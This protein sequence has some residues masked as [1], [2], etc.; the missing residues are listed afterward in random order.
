MRTL[1]TVTS[2]S[3]MSKIK[4]NFFVFDVET[5]KLEPMPENFVFAVIYGYNSQKVIYS[6]SEFKKEIE[7]PKYKNK[8]L[9]AHN[10]EFDLLS[11]FGNIYTEVDNTAVFNGK[12]ISAKY[13]DITFADSL[14][15]YPTSVEK[16]GKLIGLEKMKNTKVSGQK[17]RK[18]N[19]TDTDIEY[20]ITDCKIVF[21]ALLR[22]FEMTGAIKITLPSLAM[23]DF[24]KNYLPS[25][26]HFSEL[27]DE[28]YES[29]YGGRTEA[30]KIGQVNAHV[31]DINS[32][33]P[34]AMI[35]TKFPDIKNLKKETLIDVKY[36][37][38]ILKYY[39]GLASVKV[40]HKDTYFGF[41]PCRMEVNKSEKLVFPV[42]T[43]ETVVNFNELRFAVEYGA[44][45][46]LKV[47]Y[48]IF[49]NPVRS[50]F[51]N[52]IDDNYKKRNE[53]ADELN[54][55]IYKLKMNSLYGRFAMRMKLSTTYYD[56]IPFY[57]I[58]ELKE[59]DKRCDIQLFNAQ[60]NDC[61]LITENEKFK[62]SFFSIPT[63]SSY[64]TSTARIILLKALLQNENN[65][66]CY[67]DTDSIFLEGLF[68]GNISDA[69][70]DFKKENKTVIRV[71]G[72]KNYAYID[73]S[74]TEIQVIKGISKNSVKKIDPITKEI[75]FETQKY[76]KT[77]Q[78]LRNNKEAGQ[79]YTMKKTLKHSYDKRIVL[80]DGNTKP[81]NI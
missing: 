76:F 31:F 45:E 37:L 51:I 5:T 63:Y 47:N 48:V 6:V 46:I 30:F 13:N 79:A 1:K 11:I 60:R 67:C 2:K 59:A 38:F 33:Y 32:M 70:G 61:Y 29:Y 56:E 73:E 23:Y 22:I 17:L 24:R 20:C 69:L 72:L 71:L 80:S 68:E 81:I 77:K 8:Y 12:F 19:I 53:S 28:F 62:N 26:L 39:E 14:N 54:R 43:F 16:I 44:V 42:G 40:K 9:F 65:G 78:S 18:D 50:P 7:N 58:Q 49:S 41:L 10:A 66:V 21:K 36:L 75:S 27:V 15:I 3:D 52:F 55:M 74:G 25:D 35:Y 57:L 34:Y 64:I 4:Y